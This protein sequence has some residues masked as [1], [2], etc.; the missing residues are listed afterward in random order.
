M[1]HIGHLHSPLGGRMAGARVFGCA[2]AERRLHFLSYRAAMGDLADSL[3]LMKLRDYCPS[4]RKG[5]RRSIIQE[6]LH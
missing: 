3:H 4:I 2:L 1:D 6:V 5:L